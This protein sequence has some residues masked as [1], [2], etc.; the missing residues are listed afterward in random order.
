MKKLIV[1]AGILLVSL[2]AGHALDAPTLK[3][4]LWAIHTVTTANPGNEVAEKSYN[5]CRTHASDK[6]EE[7]A[8]NS[9]PGCSKTDDVMDGN[10]RTFT[11]TCHILGLDQITHST[12]TYN[13][14]TE[15][16]SEAHTTVSKSVRGHT[17]VDGVSDSKYV[18]PCPKASDS[19]SRP[20]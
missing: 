8:F 20:Q 7:L 17:S 4:G 6:E 9:V 19:S 2:G 1:P 10:K 3:E 12:V 18:G 14:D 16:H 13:G 5:K 15:F 11:I